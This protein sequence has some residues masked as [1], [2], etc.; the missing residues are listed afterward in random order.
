VVT[1]AAVVGESILRIEPLELGVG[2][3]KLNR[4][5]D[6]HAIASQGLG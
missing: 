3:V 2:E 5:E 1:I 6:A 4:H